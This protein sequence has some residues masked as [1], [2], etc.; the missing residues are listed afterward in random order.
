MKPTRVEYVYGEPSS[1]T[2]EM[3]LIAAG[4]RVRILS[5]VCNPVISNTANLAWGF[6]LMH[7]N[8]RDPVLTHN[9]YNINFTPVNS[10]AG[11]VGIPP[12]NLPSYGIMSTD[13]LVVK[14]HGAGISAACVTYQ[15]G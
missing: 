7:V 5:I 2:A 1:A 6:K 15:G 10:S 12:I 8:D 4:R 14:G 13:G 3:T 9:I 11:S